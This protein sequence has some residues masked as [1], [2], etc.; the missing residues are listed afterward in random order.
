MQFLGHRDESPQLSQ[1]RTGAVAARISHK[2]I[3]L[4]VAACD[5][6]TCQ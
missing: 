3:L 2:T 5:G 1:R 6:G 4:E